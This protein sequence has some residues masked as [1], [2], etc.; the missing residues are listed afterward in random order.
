[1]F[2][3]WPMVVSASYFTHESLYAT[4]VKFN[5]QVE[6]F[7]DR[8]QSVFLQEFTICEFFDCHLTGAVE[9]LLK[10]VGTIEV[11]LLFS[12]TGFNPDDA[13]AKR[14]SSAVKRALASVGWTMIARQR[15]KEHNADLRDFYTVNF[16]HALR[17][18]FTLSV[19]LL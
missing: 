15:P 4:R 10:L 7:S 14:M 19:T 8:Y 11:G 2:S 5:D 17:F 9:M 12:A 18:S 16:N 13:R 3:A 6:K 1:M